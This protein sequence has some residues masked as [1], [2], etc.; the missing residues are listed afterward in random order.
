MKASA[1]TSNLG[2][3]PNIA[4]TDYHMFLHLKRFLR[5][6]SFGSDDEVITTVEDG[7]NNLDSEFFL[8]E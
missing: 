7:L 3:S 1:Y 5:G 6:K 2:Y 4:P 8:M